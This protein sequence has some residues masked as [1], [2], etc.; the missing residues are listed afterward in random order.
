MASMYY[1]LMVITLVCFF[2]GLFFTVKRFDTFDKT[3]REYNAS[4]FIAVPLLVVNLIFIVILCYQSWNVET[5]YINAIGTYCT[6]VDSMEYMVFVF[7]AFFLMNVA[8]IMWNSY[9]LLIDAFYEPRG[10]MQH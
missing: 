7:Y 10:R 3:G 1:I 6:S 9:N 4:F 2:I 8:L 5:A